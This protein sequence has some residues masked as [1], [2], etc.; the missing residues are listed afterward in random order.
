VPAL[1]RFVKREP[2]WRVHQAVAAILALEAE[3]V[4]PRL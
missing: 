4:D 3:V 2:Q 1:E